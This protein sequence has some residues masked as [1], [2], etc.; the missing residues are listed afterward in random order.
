M[1]C[2]LPEDAKLDIDNDYMTPKYAWENIAHLIPKDKV[3]WE[4]FYGN[5][6]SGKYLTELGFNTI[7]EPVDFFENELKIGQPKLLDIRPFSESLLRQFN[8]FESIMSL[9]K[10]KALDIRQFSESL[11]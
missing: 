10:E 11:W 2:L 3:I 4:A 6:D 9:L 5:G 8:G 7:H 1:A